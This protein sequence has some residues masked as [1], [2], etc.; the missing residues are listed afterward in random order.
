MIGIAMTSEDGYCNE[1][2]YFIAQQS[3]FITKVR[4]FTWGRTHGMLLIQRHVSNLLIQTRR[5]VTSAHR[6]NKSPGWKRRCLGTNKRRNEHRKLR[7]NECSPPAGSCV[8]SATLTSALLGRV[9]QCPAACNASAPCH[10]HLLSL[11]CLRRRAA[12][13]TAALTPP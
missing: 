10:P 12:F 9:R 11:Y 8:M 2:I 3:A 13:V 6:L 1:N 4:T 5:S 7:N